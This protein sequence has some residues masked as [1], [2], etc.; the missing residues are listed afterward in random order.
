LDSHHKHLPL[1]S[2]G[3]ELLPSKT[4]TKELPDFLEGRTETLCGAEGTKAEC[5]VVT[6]FDASMILFNGLITNDKFCLSLV[7][8]Q[9]LSWV[10]GPR[11][12]VGERRGPASHPEGVRPPSGG[13]HATKVAGSTSVAAEVRRR[14]AVGSGLSTS[15][16]VDSRRGIPK[17]FPAGGL[18]HSQGED[19]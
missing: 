8:S 4:R 9:K 16:G 7:S 14:A 2:E 10:R 12:G 1:P 13:E 19:Q 11:V 17:Q 6:L 18:T 3:D 15:P 5:G